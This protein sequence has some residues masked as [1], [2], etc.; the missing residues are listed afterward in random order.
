MPQV[1]NY[2]T[3]DPKRVVAN[4]TKVLATGNMKI[5]EKGSYDL[6]IT[7]CGFI[8]HYNQSGFI[9][10]YKDDMVS[11]VYQFLSQHGMGWDAWLEDPHSYLY[12]VSYRGRLLA[13]IIREL[14]PIF[15]A[16]QPVIEADQKA[17]ARRNAE[18]QLRAL[19][20]RLRYDLVKQKDQVA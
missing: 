20:A 18:A 12:D 3:P 11:F 16:Y 6:L 8:A 9:A 13:D 4:I 14:I 17:R 5:L 19:A 10:T 7:H 15:K 2:D 1:R